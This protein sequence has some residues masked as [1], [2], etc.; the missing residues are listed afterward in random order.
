MRVPK[1][2]EGYQGIRDQKHHLNREGE[3]VSQCQVQIS[4]TKRQDSIVAKSSCS[5]FSGCMSL[6]RLYNP[7]SLF[8]HIWNED[9]NNNSCES[10]IK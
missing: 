4:P 9:S 8:P 2:R 3:K 1:E 6:D 5:Q 10:W 7:M